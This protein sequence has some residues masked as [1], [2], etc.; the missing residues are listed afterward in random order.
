MT[1]ERL[2]ELHEAAKYAKSHGSGNVTLPADELLEVL[3]ALPVEE[4]VA[5]PEADAIAPEQPAGP[6]AVEA[7]GADPAAPVTEEKPVE[8]V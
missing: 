7:A 8:A 5:E 3:P 1:P 4:K 2:A 6:V